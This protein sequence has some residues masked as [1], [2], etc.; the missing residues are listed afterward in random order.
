MTQQE[1]EHLIESGSA[2]RQLSLTDFHILIQRER[3]RE[4]MAFRQKKKEQI[5]YWEVFL[6]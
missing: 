6:I 4:E 3:E 1:I 5:I 2:V